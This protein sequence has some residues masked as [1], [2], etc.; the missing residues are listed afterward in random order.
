MA[1]KA[2][3]RW[4][5]TY[6]Q[7]YW[8]TGQQAVLRLIVNHIKGNPLSQEQ[9]RLDEEAIKASLRINGTQGVAPA[10]WESSI[11]RAE[12][13]VYLWGQIIA[14]LSW[15]AVG[16]TYD[17][18]LFDT[19]VDRL[20]MIMGS[21]EPDS[22]PTDALLI[23]AMLCLDDYRHNLKQGLGSLGRL[24]NNRDY[25]WKQYLRKPEPSTG[26][27]G[28]LFKRLIDR[29]LSTPA[30]TFDALLRQ[31]IGSHKGAFTISDWRF[32]IVNISEPDTLLKIFRDVQTYG[33]YVYVEPGGHAYLFR[34]NTLRTACRY[35]LVTT[36]LSYETSLHRPGVKSARLAHTAEESGACVDFTVDGGDVIRLSAASG[37]LYDISRQSAGTETWQQLSAGLG[38]A[39]V[40]TRLRGLDVI[41]RL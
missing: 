16:T 34:S 6:R 14:P 19:Y 10:R 23:Q 15:A 18:D 24:N 1:L 11:L 26:Y 12:D 4:L 29:W 28:A 22:E 5:D 30:L 9:A 40:E 8:P 7:S 38:I 27:Y 35:E 33:R 32:Y 39:D 21:R 13:N 17:K 31:V 20:D 3:D 37:D 25:S 41:E 36:Y 2:I